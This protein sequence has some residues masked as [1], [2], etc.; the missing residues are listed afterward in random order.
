MAVDFFFVLSGFIMCLTYL[1]A[2]ETDG[3]LAMP[4]FLV[5]PVARIVPLNVAVLFALMLAGMASWG[6]LGRNIFFDDTNIGFDLPANLLMLQGL[7]IG[8]NLNGPSWSISV[9]FAAYYLFPLLIA[10]VF[11][12]RTAVWC[13]ALLVAGAAL[14]A[15]AAAYPRLELTNDVAPGSLV[16]CLSEFVLGM[17]AYRLSAALARRG[18][19]AGDLATGCLLGAGVAGLVARVDL[20]VAL[21]CPLIV[22]AAAANR[23][24]VARL[25]ASPP[26]H[27]L[28]VISYSIYLIH[29]PLRPLAIL[30]FT[31]L[32][33]QPVGPVAALAFALAGSLAV[34]P[35][36]WLTY[37]FI[38]HPGRAVVRRW[39]AVLQ[40]RPTS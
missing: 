14:C 17:G 21:L 34:I 30:A 13:G 20:F 3:L 40:G 8:G 18:H 7:G 15:L 39:G 5:K 36:A 28:G 12:R 19:A 16:R 33:P 1:P 29:S 2:F 27:F 35:L 10:L 9:E 31:D 23:G 24:R 38:E 6:A 4:G 22:V 25:L 11:A 26:L 37:R 32:H